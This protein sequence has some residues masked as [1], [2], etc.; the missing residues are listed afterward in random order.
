MPNSELL[1][2]IQT[3]EQ[4]ATKD[5]MVLWYDTNIFNFESFRYVQYYVYI[6]SLVYISIEEQYKHKNLKYAMI[7]FQWFPNDCQHFE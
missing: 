4:I 2:K 5:D 1:L 6:L 7:V 3:Q